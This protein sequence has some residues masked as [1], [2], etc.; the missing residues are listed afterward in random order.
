[1]DNFYFL[2]QEKLQKKFKNTDTFK[3]LLIE[4]QDLIFQT[5]EKESSK[6]LNPNN[7][8]NSNA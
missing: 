5:Y 2:L 6:K 4:P 3:E 8:P 7:E 1:M